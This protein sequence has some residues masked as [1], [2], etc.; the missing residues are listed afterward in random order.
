VKEA[1]EIL[2]VPATRLYY[3]VK[4]LQRLG[5]IVV[6]DRNMVSGI[7]ERTYGA[8]ATSWSM[9]PSL[10]ASAISTSG[11]LRA[12]MNMV[13][14][15]I[16]AVIQERPDEPLGDDPKSPIPAIGLTRLALDGE[17]LAE[18]ERR[19]QALMDEFGAERPEDAMGKPQYH[20]FFAVY[21][22]PR[23]AGGEGPER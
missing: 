12:L 18:V 6:T 9:S 4:I 15:E 3:H 21:P 17:E 10:A 14:S 1:A 16:E 22:V 20:M 11:V 7:E 23:S 19:F 2:E 5:L 13:R 8:V